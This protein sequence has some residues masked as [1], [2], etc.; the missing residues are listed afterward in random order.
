MMGE[1]GLLFV[2]NQRIEQTRLAPQ[3]IRTTFCCR[4]EDVR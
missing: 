2:S 4:Q 3:L 1:S